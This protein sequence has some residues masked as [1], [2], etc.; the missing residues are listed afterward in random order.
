[1]DKITFQYITLDIAEKILRLRNY[2]LF[3]S[4]KTNNNSNSTVI[5]VYEESINKIISS[6]DELICRINIIN[7]KS[8]K[9]EIFAIQRSLSCC[10]TAIKELHKELHYLSSDWLKPETYTFIEQIFNDNFNPN[11]KN[12]ISI[13]LTDEYTFIETNLNKQFKKIIDSFY[14][15]SLE[16]L[17]GENPTVILPKIEYSNPLNWPIL[18]H[19]LGH[20]EVD[21]IEKLCSTQYFKSLK[22]GEKENSSPHRGNPIKNPKNF[23]ARS[24]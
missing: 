6:L 13:I 15:N 21:K 20:T 1:M 19:E 17:S 18:V 4:S 5:M 7:K 23:I 22:N 16:I 9:D 3:N 12:K 14:S 11:K 2:I 8:T 24:N 10:Y